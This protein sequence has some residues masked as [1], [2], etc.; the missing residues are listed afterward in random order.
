MGRRAGCRL[1]HLGCQSFQLRGYLVPPPPLLS[2]DPGALRLITFPDTTWPSAAARRSAS[3][4]SSRPFPT[5]RSG[6]GLMRKPRRRRRRAG[7]ADC[8]SGF[9]LSPQRRRRRERRGDREEGE[10]E[11]TS[12]P[13][14]YTA[15]DAGAQEEDGEE[16][17]AASLH[18]H[19]TTDS[20]PPGSARR[21]AARHAGTE[22]AV[23]A[24]A[25]PE[26]RGAAGGAGSALR[27]GAGGRAERPALP[28]RGLA[29]TP[30]EPRQAAAPPRG[31]MGE[32]NLCH[33]PYIRAL[34]D[35]TRKTPD[36]RGPGSQV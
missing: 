16:A 34:P 3:R 4:R 10:G 2:R 29:A 31:I 18:A 14:P 8:R 23:P 26:D 15:R 35:T 30:S 5:L 24:P 19:T 11:A 13:G 12:L 20:P 27:G 25:Q 33:H 32:G 6:P 7:E 28:H 17:V 36:P 21:A 22:G 1:T 9:R